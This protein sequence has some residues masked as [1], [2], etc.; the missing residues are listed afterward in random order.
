MDNSFLKVSLTAFAVTKRFFDYM[1]ILEKK[2][3]QT[4]RVKA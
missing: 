4:G 2:E 3:G 1:E